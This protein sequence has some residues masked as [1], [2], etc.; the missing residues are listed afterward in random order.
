MARRDRAP[1]LNF[2]DEAA[3]QA[4]GDAPGAASWRRENLRRY[5]TARWST[6]DIV[7]VGEAPG[8]QGARRSG[9][10]FTSERQL[11]GAGWTEP[12]ATIVHG[13]LGRLG[14]EERVLLWN[15]CVLHPHLPGRPNSNRAPD[16]CELEASAELLESVCRGR[17]VVAVGRVA[18][19]RTGASYLRHP[20]R[21]GATQFR[22]GL[23]QVLEPLAVAQAGN[24]AD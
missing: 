21:G 20:A 18:A 23:A 17:Q 4:A 14:A 1:A 8:Y 2:Y 11:T 6:A 15:A 13:E 7:L 22:L 5:L 16:R 10:A 12:S 9:I 19:S 3:S 24:A